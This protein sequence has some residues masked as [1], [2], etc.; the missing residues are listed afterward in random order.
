LKKK[1]FGLSGSDYFF[2]FQVIM[3]YWFVGPQISKMFES[4]RGVTITWL[5]FAEVFIVLNLCLTIATYR[6]K[7]TRIVWQTRFIY[8]NWTVLLTPMV[9]LTLF[10]CVWT[11]QDSQIS[12]IILSATSLLVVWTWLKGKSITDPLPRGLLVG[13]FRVVPHLYLSYC[14]FHAGSGDGISP[15]TVF[16]ANVTATARVISLF[17]QGRKSGWD[18]KTKASLYSEIANETSWLVTTVTWLIYR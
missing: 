6:H 3:T 10:K 15:T 5:L 1:L 8:W 13:L 12:A 17:I 7:P 2:A 11:K 9:I 14:I 18:E 4:V 16:A